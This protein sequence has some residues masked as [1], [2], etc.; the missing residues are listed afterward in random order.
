VDNLI[1]GSDYP[2]ADHKPSIV[3]DAVALG[4]NISKATVQKILWDNPAR[5]YGLE[6]L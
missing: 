6:A 2:H 1:F 4:E 3:A 5:F